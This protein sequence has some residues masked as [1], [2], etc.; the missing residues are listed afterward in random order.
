MSGA[1]NDFILFDS[2]QLPVKDY[3]ALA[4]KLCRRRLSV[5]ADGILI[6][7]HSS[8]IP[9]VRYFNSD[10][11]EAFCGNGTRCA[12]AWLCLNGFTGKSFIMHTIAGDL[13]VKMI[14]GG[15]FR[16]RMPNVSAVDLDPKGF[17]DPFTRVFFADTGA[18]H[19]VVPVKNI[20]NAEVDK[21]GRMLRYNKA[22]G[23]GANVDFVEVK[24]DMLVIRT[25]ERGVE[26]ETL[27][28]GTGV[29]ASALSCAAAYNIPSP[30]M[31]Q[32]ST[33]DVLEVEFTR[34]GA[35]AENIYL[36]G[37]AGLVYYGELNE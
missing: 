14:S 3:A 35:G 13:A 32:V 11:S 23:D 6:V 25:Y 17:F 4:L 29:T 10:G 37:P 31:V 22:F 12:A 5:G 30:V 1:G 36:T 27:A 28:C 24:D 33:G 21:Y 18:P 2:G 8:A 15:I 9:E 34:K 26:A 7:G 16:V 20:K 19:C